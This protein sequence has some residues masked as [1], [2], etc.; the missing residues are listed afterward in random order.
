[1]YRQVHVA[2]QQLAYWRGSGTEHPVL[3]L[4]NSAPEAIELQISLPK[5]LARTNRH[6]RDHLDPSYEIEEKNGEFLIHLWPCYGRILHPF[7]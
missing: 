6:W 3:V 5:N 1:G 7:G 2:A 4:V